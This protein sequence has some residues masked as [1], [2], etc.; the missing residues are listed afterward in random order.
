MKKLNVFGNSIKVI[1]AEIED[2]ELAGYYDPVA[3][4]V[5]IS[6]DCQDK[7]QTYLHEFFHIVWNRIG[8][9]QTQINSDL[10]E[11]IVDSFATAL[12]ENFKQ[13]KDASKLK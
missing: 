13:I 11:I 5:T 2:P 1:V 8:L 4:T 12:L 9:N 6:K 10:Q 3:N 7:F